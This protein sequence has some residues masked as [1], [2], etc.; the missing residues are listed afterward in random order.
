MRRKPSVFLLE[1]TAY[2]QRN[3]RARGL[4]LVVSLLLAAGVLL[5]FFSLYSSLPGWWILPA[6]GMLSM[7]ALTLSRER[8]GTEIIVYAVTA[9]V[10]AGVLVM[11]GSGVFRGLLYMLNQTITA[12]NVQFESY[13]TLFA[14]SSIRDTDRL[15]FGVVLVLFS[16]VILHRLIYKRA[17]FLTTVLVYAVLFVTVLLGISQGVGAVLLLIT[18]WLLFWSTDTLV[19]QGVTKTAALMAGVILLLAGIVSATENYQAVKA[20][21]ECRQEIV[22]RV[23]EIRFGDDTLPQ[24]DLTEADQ[25]VGDDT[26]RLRLSFENAQE[27]YL[28]GYVGSEYQ[29]TGWEPLSEGAYSTEQSAGMLKWLESQKFSPVSQYVGYETAKSGE[30]PELSEVSVENTGAYRRYA[31]APYEAGEIRAGSVEPEFDWQYRSGALFGMR[32]YLFTSAKTEV[33]EELMAASGTDSGDSA[34]YNDA[35]NVYCAFVKD[36]YLAVDADEKQRLRDLFF[37]GQDIENWNIYQVTNQIRVVLQETASYSETPYRYTGEEDFIAWFLERAKV[38]NASYFATAATMA[39]RAAE[40]PARYV[41]GYY[42]SETSADKL[43]GSKKQ[44]VELTGKD[45]HAWTEIYIDGIGWMPVEV[46]PGF[47]YAEYTTQ[48]VLD[49]PQ[50]T[51]AVTNQEE[52][53]ELH[54][55]TT[56][57]IESMDPKKEQKD[58]PVRKTLRV[59][60]ILLAAAILLELVL[61]LIQMQQKLRNLI[62]EKK[63]RQSDDKAA[64]AALYD[65]V[66]RILRID[67]VPGDSAFPYERKEDIAE[68]YA[69]IDEADYTR[70]LSIVQKVRFGGSGLR[71]NEIKAMRTFV[72]KL[73]AASY[74]NAG[75]RKKLLMKFW[76]CV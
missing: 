35:E 15:M 13:T 66:S 32:D 2:R 22:D 54:G 10:V 19:H 71:A 76:Y 40:I 3:S 14:L 28:R 55:S 34:Q 8:G 36:N 20:V 64:A 23:D 30:R 27:M 50:T 42:L 59:V 53:D 65:R 51:V 73:T 52:Q 12:W 33:P 21:S 39:Y 25:L 46:V 38:G 69:A 60:G 24:G 61:L 4:E 72:E 17:L 63:I 7:T 6:A 49:M 45:A 43:N 74:E 75:K 41:E 44:S 31:Y 58:T 9:A 16:M 47:Y 18:G 5:S 48:Q 68:T 11:N 57:Q 56:D 1:D 67:R 62:Y 37:A 29:K 70:F 26:E